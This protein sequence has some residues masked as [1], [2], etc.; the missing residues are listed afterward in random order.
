MNSPRR[1][2]FVSTPPPE[3]DAADKIPQQQGIK[4]G[5]KFLMHALEKNTPNGKHRHSE[6]KKL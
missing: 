1:K 2:P 6:R 5:A 3:R 4:P